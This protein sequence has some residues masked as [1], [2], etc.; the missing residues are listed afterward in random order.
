MKR[1]VLL[2]IAPLLLI[3]SPRPPAAASGSHLVVIVMEN[4][5]YGQLI[6]N[7][8]CPYLNHLA[9]TGRLYTDYHAVTHP[10]LPNYLAFTVGSPCG[11]GGTDS[12]S[13]ICRQTG[14][15]GQLQGR[16]ISWHV[17]VQSM[18]APCST[19]GT[20]LYAV[21]HNPGTIYAGSVSHNC[22]GRDTVLP[23]SFHTLPALSFVI[24]NICNDMH[25]C[26]AATGDSWL[27]NEVPKFLAI[28]GTRVV[29]VFDEGTTNQG[30]GG[31]IPVVEVGAGVPQMHDS[32]SL[33]H[34]G[35]LAGIEQ[36]FGL[37]EIRGAAGAH[38]MPL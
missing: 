17:W 8:C 24:P 7:G 21:R 29:V 34:Y 37:Q 12:V 22:W 28:P 11:K 31:H 38:V 5:E 2:V 1:L 20:S 23:S 27:K 30:G 35:L 10:S 19:L 26:S 4:H 3:P 32:T 6:G 15:L 13:P 9:A 18:P 36:R 16:G 33:T 14:L 25:S